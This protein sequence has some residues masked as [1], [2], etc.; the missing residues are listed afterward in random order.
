MNDS[1]KLPPYVSIKRNRHS[2]DLIIARF[3]VGGKRYYRGGFST[4]EEAALWA[5]TEK[6]KIETE[7]NTPKPQTGYQQ[8]ILIL[9]GSWNGDKYAVRNIDKHFI[10][11][12][13]D[14]F[15]TEPFYQRN[16]ETN[17]K[18]FWVIKSNRF[19]PPTLT[20]VADWRG[21]CRALLELQGS[22]DLRPCKTHKGVQTR[23]LRLRIWAQ[24]ELLNAF[25]AAVPAAP[26]RIQ[27]V[28]TAT[29]TT[30]ALYYQSETEICDILDYLD[31][32]PRCASWWGK[33]DEILKNKGNA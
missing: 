2:P 14:L 18:D 27:T 17:H 25:A 19:S 7:I 13:A 1:I 20:D 23:R 24:P 10:L 32:Q 29:G 12:V 9:S 11:A 4:A 26:K 21:F 33:A 5:Q 3:S 30:Y 6:A 22:L 28:N 31:G 15:R 8:A 16:S